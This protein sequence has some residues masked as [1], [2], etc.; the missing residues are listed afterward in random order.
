MPDLLLLNWFK[1]LKNQQVV[2]EG[3]LHF[4]HTAEKST[5]C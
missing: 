2:P 1:K 4:Q 3:V 5:V